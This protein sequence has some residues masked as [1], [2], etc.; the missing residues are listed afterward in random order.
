MGINKKKT[1]KII[2]GSIVEFGIAIAFLVICL[3]IFYFSFLCGRSYLWEDLL[4]MSYPAANFFATSLASWH[5]PLWLSGLHN[6][7]PLFCEPWIYYPF[8]WGMALFVTDGHLTSLAIQWYLVGQLFMAGFFTYI[9]LAAHRLNVWASIAGAIVMVFSGFLSLHIVHGGM[10]HAFLWLPLELYFVKRIV[11]NRSPERDYVFLILSIVMSFLA[12]FPQYILYNGY[13]MAAYWLFMVSQGGFQMGCGESSRCRWVVSLFLECLK[14]AGVMLVVALLCLFVILPLAQAW[15]ETPRQEYGFDMIADQSTPWYYLIHGLVAN[16]FGASNGNGSGVPFWGFNKDTLEYKTWHGGYWMYMEFAFY[17]GQMA[18]LALVIATAN[19]RRL[20]SGRR[21]LVFFLVALGPLVLLMLGRY[22]LLYNVFFHVV[23]GFS[24]FRS[25]SRIGGLVDFCAAVVVAMLL[26]VLMKKTMVLRVRKPLLVS[27]VLYMV[28]F[29]WLTIFGTTRFPELEQAPLWSNALTETSI[30]FVLYCLMALVISMIVWSK[31]ARYMSYFAVV[32]V[33]LTFFDLY[34]ALHHFHQGTIQ[35]EKYYADKNGLISQ[36]VKMREQSGPFRFAQLRD[37]IISEEVIFPRNTAYLYPGFEVLEGYLMFNLNSF[38]A[39]S[40]ITNQQARLDI[41]NVGVVANAERATG[42]VSLS[43]YT[44]SLP[45]VKFYRNVR[46]YPDVKALCADLDSGRLD[47]RREIGLLRDDCVT[48][49]I[50]TT[51]PPV[52]AEAQIHFI[53]KNPDEYQISYNTVTPGII[54]ISET[55]YPGW[56]AD[57]GRYPII[58][59]FGAFKGIV[60]S[61]AGQGVITVR[62]R[63]RVLILGL[64]ISFTTLVVVLGIM[65]VCIVRRKKRESL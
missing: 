19:I 9:F 5:F 33:G 28:F 29:L 43:R 26:D 23:P 64:A 34:L 63:P 24:I 10:G 54:F 15:G 55:F 11:E 59:A 8:I 18:I 22:G 31:A 65:T 51:A 42:R 12:G 49:G 30:S 3:G 13:F 25:P 39:F 45:R 36:M 7:T 27:V 52:Q 53:P 1:D 38:S 58:R 14:M 48:Y 47:Y 41:Q 20:W 21:E 17:A 44:N 46:A 40:S 32:L 60:I 37:G 57:A 6:G 2:R 16:F 4:Y 61:Q 56:E 35:P 50:N 62:F